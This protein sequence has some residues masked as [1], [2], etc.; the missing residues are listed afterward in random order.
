MRQGGY[1]ET[2][3]LQTFSDRLATGGVLVLR[4]HGNAAFFSFKIFCRASLLI[5]ARSYL[6]LLSWKDFLLWVAEI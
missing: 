3:P 4:R 1:G 2:T 6:K 5:K